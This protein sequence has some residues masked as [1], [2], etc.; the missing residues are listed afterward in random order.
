M[1]PFTLQDRQLEGQESQVLV[2][3]LGYADK[4]EQLE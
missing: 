4:N 2:A 3:L 1:H